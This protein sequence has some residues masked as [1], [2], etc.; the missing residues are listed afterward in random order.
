MKLFA[1]SVLLFVTWPRVGVSQSRREE[2][3]I[4]EAVEEAIQNNPGLNAARLGLAVADTASITAG[5]RPNPVVSTSA[6]HLDLL[7][8]GY[9]DQNNAGPPEMALRIDV[10]FERGGK[11]QARLATASFERRIAEAAIADATRRLKQ[12]VTL[13]CVDLL[14]AQARLALA[15]E[16]LQSLDRLVQLN[17]ARVKAGSIA[18]VE[19]TRSRVAMLQFRANKRTAELAV[20]TSQ[21][22]LHV[23]LG[24]PPGG[25]GI[26]IAGGLKPSIPPAPVNLEALRAAA[27]ASRPDLASLQLTQARSQA[28]LRLQVAQGKIDYTFGME[29]RRQQG[30]NGRGN[31]LGFFASAPLPLFNRNQGEIARARAEET[32]IV[33]RIEALEHEINGEVTAAWQEYETART[34]VTEIERDLLAPSTEARDTTAYVYQAGASSLMEVLDAQRAFN[35]TMSAYTGAQ[36]DYRRAAERLEAAIGKEM[37]P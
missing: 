14:E 30:V 6:D 8:T 33:R 36:A 17:D 23:L 16:N 12:D 31:S 35:E 2:L 5:L 10:P 28:D 29:Y 34:Q 24:R 26:A 13:A 11:R 37:V 19:L 25:N 7:G 9:N 21:I 3:T 1:L 20:T 32:Q 27:I 22:R 15:D 18:P 4:A